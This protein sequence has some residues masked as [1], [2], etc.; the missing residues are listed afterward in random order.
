MQTYTVL[1]LREFQTLSNFLH[2]IDIKVINWCTIT[3]RSRLQIKVQNAAP[4]TPV[5]SYNSWKLTRMVRWHKYRLTD[6]IEQA[7]SAYL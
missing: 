4:T 3:H 7:T 6:Y 5:T 2:G 1:T